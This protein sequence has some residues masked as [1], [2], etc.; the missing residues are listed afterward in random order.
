MWRWHAMEE[1]EHKAVAFDTFT[2]AV[3]GGPVGRWLLRA[4]VMV[5]AT[6]LFTY[7]ISRN[8]AD[9]FKQDGMGALRAWARLFGYLWGSPGLLRRITP[10]YFAY[11][12]PGFHPWD[13]DDRA[14]LASIQG[15]L[16]AG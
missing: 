3:R 4:S 5:L 1:I 8:V 6:A 7:T 13:V 15:E 14:L 16:A 11:Y 12:R 10:A 2:A 9:L